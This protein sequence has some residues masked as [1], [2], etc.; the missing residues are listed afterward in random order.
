VDSPGSSTWEQFIAEALAASAE[1]DEFDEV[2]RADDV[3][4]WLE[5]LARGEK[6][7]CPEPL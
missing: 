2:Y 7:V 5:R 6:A 1:I 4:H 3:H